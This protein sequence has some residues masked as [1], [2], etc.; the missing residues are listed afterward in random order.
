MIRLAVSLVVL[1]AGCVP[2][3]GTLVSE[4]TGLSGRYSEQVVISDHPHH[5]LYGHVIE[6]QRNGEITRA[7]VISQRRDGVHNLRF[8]EAWMRG[9]ELPFSRSGALSGCS[10][11]QCLNRH[12]GMILLSDALFTHARNNGLQVRLIGGQDNVDIRVPAELFQL[13]PP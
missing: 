1:L 5:V 9:V 10:H 12:A 6:A 2:Q 8:Q 7:L 4:A 11:G 3:S 13:P